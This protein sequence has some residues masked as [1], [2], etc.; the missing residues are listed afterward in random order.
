MRCVVEMTAAG[1]VG[2]RFTLGRRALD[3]F[4][5]NGRVGN[6]RRRSEHSLVGAT[7][8]LLMNVLFA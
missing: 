5:G 2:L 4:G 8:T 7:A 3:C 6:R 1:T